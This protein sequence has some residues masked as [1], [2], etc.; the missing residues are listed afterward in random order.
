MTTNQVS[1]LDKAMELCNSMMQFSGCELYSHNT[2]SL[3]RSLKTTVKTFDSDD[4]ATCDKIE[5]IIKAVNLLLEEEGIAEAEADA[6]KDDEYEDSDE[7]YE[8][9]LYDYPDPMNSVEEAFECLALEGFHEY[10]DRESEILFYESLEDEAKHE[11]DME[12]DDWADTPHEDINT[13]LKQ[14]DEEIEDRKTA[15]SIWKAREAVMNKIVFSD[16]DYYPIHHISWEVDDNNI[17]VDIVISS[18]RKY[19]DYIA[20]NHC[21]L[22][23]NCND[24]ETNGFCEALYGRLDKF[25]VVD[26]EGKVILIS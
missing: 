10:E 21:Q 9:C 15:V 25:C 3:L 8:D 11:E 22:G 12:I 7:Y 20:E 4:V 16:G 17:P 14:I 5:D 1:F 26:Y 2:E 18:R 24:E 19:L 23:Y 6:Y 13:E